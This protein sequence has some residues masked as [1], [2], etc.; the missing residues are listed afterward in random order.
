M[1]HTVVS[2]E[3]IFAEIYDLSSEQ[4]VGANFLSN[5]NSNLQISVGNYNN[6]INVARHSHL[7]NQRRLFLTEEIIIILS[8]T[9]CLKIYDDDR[10]FLESIEFRTG[11]IL[12][13]LRGGHE[14]MF[15]SPTKLIE[16]KQGPYDSPE[17][18]KVLW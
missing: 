1:N 18:D 11:A 5:A 13:L 9:G 3:V 8:G 2:N 7:L 10:V 14:L 6:D 12:H 16:I 4:N 17:K 15:S